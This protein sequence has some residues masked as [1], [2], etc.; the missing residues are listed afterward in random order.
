MTH[1]DLG[2]RRGGTGGKTKE[3]RRGGQGEIVAPDLISLFKK[4]CWQPGRTECHPIISI[5]QQPW[6]GEGRRKG[7][8]EKKNGFDIQAGGPREVTSSWPFQ[9]TWPPAG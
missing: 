3:L 4:L 2:G 5:H 1:R 9:R 6:E 7:T 8:R